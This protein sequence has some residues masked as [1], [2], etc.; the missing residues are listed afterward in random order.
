[1]INWTDLLT[2]EITQLNPQRDLLL[3]KRP[4]VVIWNI[5][6][7]CNLHCKHCYFDVT[8]RQDSQELNYTEAKALI[9]DLAKLKVPVILF[10]GGEPLLRKDIFELA[11]FAK[12][13]GI[14]TALSS[15][16][17]L[18]NAE[19]VKRIKQIGFF[20]V[21]ISLDGKEKT[22][23]AFRG[24]RGAFKASLSAIRNCKK[25]GLKVG[26]RFTLTKNNFRDLP[27]IFD[28]VEKEDINRICLYHLVYVG[29]GSSLKDKDLSHQERRVILEFIWQK[30][31]D[32][33]QKGL[34][35]EILTIDN[36]ADGVWLYLKLRKFNPQRA[37]IVFK[38]LK[39]KGGNS[40]GIRI[41]CVDNAG[42]IFPDQ[43]WHRYYLGNIH[44]TKFSTIWQNKNNSF[45][46]SLRDRRSLFKGRCQNC[47]YFSLCNGNFRARAEVA[48]DDPWADDPGCYLT[49]EEISS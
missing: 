5:T 15:N 10:S 41:A 37:K 22:N 34:K 23:D 6:S 3:Y 9:Q 26:I 29:R 31:L 36:H 42:N 46:M 13:F 16:G 30:T 48:F 14:K 25:V 8:Q 39:A 17:T 40:S 20:Y 2:K 28:L 1:M 44:Q 33:Q 18:M 4:R 47:N 11:Y 35:V 49:H 43:F 12:D 38:M 45:L 7:S 27:Y 21:G 24:Y 19:L 32:F